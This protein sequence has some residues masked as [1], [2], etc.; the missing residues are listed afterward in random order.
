MAEK[1]S[2]QLPGGGQLAAKAFEAL[3]SQ[4]QILLDQMK[5]R[6]LSSWVDIFADFYI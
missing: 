4:A 3:E 5:E 2:T 1:A 6:K